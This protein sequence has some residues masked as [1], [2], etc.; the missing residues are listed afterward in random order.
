MNNKSI[1]EGLTA[2][3]L[4]VR[5]KI[6]ITKALHKTMTHLLFFS[7]AAFPL[8]WERKDR[9]AYNKELILKNVPKDS[10]ILTHVKFW[11]IFDKDY[12]LLVSGGGRRPKVAP[13]YLS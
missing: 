12:V 11:R 9:H 13:M 1:K 7:V 3:I 6:I 8:T 2:V 4:F 10:K 5:I